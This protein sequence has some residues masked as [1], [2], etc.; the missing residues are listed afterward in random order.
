MAKRKSRV[1][2]LSTR[3]PINTLSSG[4]GRQAPS[5]RLPTEAQNIDNAMVTLEKSISK[6]SGFE[7]ID[8][9]VSN[10][11]KD[12]WD[13]G[14]NPN[15]KNLWYSWLD[16]AEDARY[17]IIINFEATS[18][19]DRLIWVKR[20][21]S[22]GWEDV[23]PSNADIPDYVRAY[24]TYGGGDPNDVLKA[25]SIG[26]NILILNRNVK[27]GFSS[28][29]TGPA[30][31]EEWSET[32]NSS[33]FKVTPNGTTGIALEDELSTKSKTGNGTGLVVRM[34]RTAAGEPTTVAEVVSAGNGYKL[35]EVVTLL[36]SEGDETPC[37][38]EILNPANSLIDLDGNPTSSIDTKGRPITYYTTIPQDP[39]AKARE[40]NKFDNYI[41]GDEVIYGTSSSN[42]VVYKTD[43]D[44]E[45][46]AS[47]TAPNAT[48]TWEPRPAD[49]GGSEAFHIPVEDWVYPDP[50][51]PELGQSLADFS[52]IKF[53]PNANDMI[54][55][56]GFSIST[57]YV[58]DRTETTLASLYPTTGSSDGRGKI[59][60]TSGSYLTAL[61]GY[62]RIISDSAPNGGTGRPYTQRVRTPDGHSY[63]DN[64]RMPMRF[65]LKNAST[66]AFEEIEWDPRTTG[67]KESNPGPAVF[68]KEDKSARHVPIN[69]MA[70]YRGR[71]FL[72]A[73]DSLFSSQIGNF[74]NLWVDNPSNIVATDPLDLQ[75]SSN[76]YSRINAMIPFADYLFINTDSDTQ[77]ELMGSENQI[78]PFTAELAPTAFYSTAPMVD[79]ILMGSQIYF[80]APNKMYLYFSTGTANINNAV[81]VSSHC[82]DYLPKNFGVVGTAPSR[83]TVFFVD[84]DN[85]NHLYM[86]TNRFSGDQV[87]QNA[88][89]RWT[90]D[91][92]YS[93]EA[94]SFFDDYVYVVVSYRRSGS[95]HTI[96]LM[97]CL[98]SEENLETPRIDDRYVLTLS[99]TVIEGTG[100]PVKSTSYD[101]NTNQTTFYLPRLWADVTSYDSIDA[102]I[103]GET[104]EDRKYEQLT[105]LEKTLSYVTDVNGTN[106]TLTT[107]VVEGDYSNDAFPSGEIYF[108]KRYTMNVELSPQFYRDD[109]NN[110]ING[111]LNLR[112]M[113]TRHF[114][115][116]RY[117]VAVQRR[118][119][120]E[121]KTIFD[122][123]Q[124][125]AFG[126]TLADTPLY[127]EQG[128][129]T[130][131]V[132]GHASDVSIFIRSN[133]TT[134]CNIT[135]IELRG[136]FKPVYSSVLD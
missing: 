10:T 63:I 65:A 94:A 104:F 36:N 91:E 106:Y 133:D 34:N 92:N 16:I 39:L 111:V 5:K 130:S 102:V 48:N 35:R 122:V 110:V 12:K 118:G 124:L 97:R 87:I 2:S 69:S 4:V 68:T 45:G 123:A 55:N 82:P 15:N 129:L 32:F 14:I 77:F 46:G 86:Y 74:D 60:Y 19:S 24:I 95:T 100:G 56:N 33:Y 67:S 127:E 49:D 11:W 119:R 132:Y 20:I 51:T 84:R 96:K 105:I 58:I 54:A 117:E 21:L 131:K 52:K 93:I 114:N 17:L 99:D 115:T 70:F 134:P 113:H 41:A 83:D 61:P 85:K 7:N 9:R 28:N 75:A 43:E 78:T 57:E 135:N 3:I 30:A 25:I 29:E 116:G 79:P 1:Q 125:G 108:G 126:Q 72:S 81:E 62:Y 80:F 103:L 120:T 22:S 73:E 47:A 121:N 31:D 98:L 23:S 112:T 13:F 27:A 6:R 40:W 26:Q 71:L 18:A 53:P 42:R 76:K 90:L 8:P 109:Q 64:R 44:V 66:F 128:E 59:Y 38:I 88:F 136:K 101:P 50:T 89:H 37:T 107:V